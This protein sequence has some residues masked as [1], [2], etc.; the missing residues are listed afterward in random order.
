M[1]LP[2]TLKNGNFQFGDFE[3][4]GDERI[5]T[6]NGTPVPLPPKV[7]KL[8]FVLVK[9]RGR[10]VVKDDLMQQVWP[11]TFVED[12]NLAYSIRLLRRALGDNSSASKYIQT[13]PRRGYRFVAE[14]RPD[15]E[16]ELNDRLRLNESISRA[17]LVDINDSS[18]IGRETELAEVTKLLTQDDVRLLTLTGPGGTGKTRL[19]RE[20]A[21][22]IESHF[23]D[24]VFFVELAAVN[25]PLLVASTIARE[26]GIKDAGTRHILD[27]LSDYFG[28]K[29]AVLI[30]DNVEQVVSAGAQFAQLLRSAP[31]LKLLVTSRGPLK[32]SFETEYLLQ[33]LA[34]PSPETKETISDLM[35][36]GAVKL[37]V[38]RALKA[39]HDLV[40]TDKNTRALSAICHQ[41]DGLP[42]ALEL[43]ASRA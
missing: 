5:L 34:L 3:L 32:L 6:K 1:G 41:L 23:P 10:I 26:V 17:D 27:L 36:F 24:G 22:Q 40:L 42:L 35:R 37:F 29:S 38:Q 30:L 19:S 9:S 8:L 18:L 12:G 4:D 43:A 15:P 14:G 21:M 25:D 7:L 20:V 28:A 2:T 13:V 16:R 39:R 31:N 33:P 11:D